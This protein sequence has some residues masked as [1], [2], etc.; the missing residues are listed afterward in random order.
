MDGLRKSR[1]DRVT[2]LCAEPDRWGGGKARDIPRLATA[3]TDLRNEFRE[4]WQGELLNPGRDGAR[5][6][7]QKA[8]SFGTRPWIATPPKGGSQ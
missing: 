7:C 8:R 5:P 6:T 1:A 2:L 3:V 4:S